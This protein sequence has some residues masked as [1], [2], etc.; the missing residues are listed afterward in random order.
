MEEVQSHKKKVNKPPKQLKLAL[1]QK[2][3]ESCLTFLKI[4][5][6]LYVKSATLLILSLSQ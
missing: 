5:M 6:K 4:K 1:N 3:K 2:K